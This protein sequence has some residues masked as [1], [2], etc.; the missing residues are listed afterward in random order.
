MIIFL[1]GFNLLIYGIDRER[2]HIFDES[3]YILAG[4][5]LAQHG[6][7]E[8]WTHPPL[9]KML[10]GAGV[11][12]FG[13]NPLGWRFMSVLFGTLSLNAMYALGLVLFESEGAALEVVIL[14]F[15]NQLLF[16]QSR[17]ALLEIFLFA[18]IAWAFVFFFRSRKS[19]S[20]GLSYSILAGVFL[21]LALATKWVAWIP[22][23]L[24]LWLEG[25]GPRTM[26][27]ALGLW[28]FV[29]L[30][31]YATVFLFCLGMVHPS[32][33]TPLAHSAASVS[34]GASRGA[35]SSSGPSRPSGSVATH[36]GA[37]DLVSLQ[38]DM[39]K[40]QLLFVQPTSSEQSHWYAWPFMITPNWYANHNVKINDLSLRSGVILLG[41]PLILWGG[42]EAV[43]FCLWAWFRNRQPTA[44]RISL[45]YFS[46]FLSWAVI[47]RKVMYFYY[48]FPAA[49]M[50]SLA[51]VF[52]FRYRRLPRW[53]H[54]V[55]VS[56]CGLVFAYFYPLLASVELPAH[57]FLSH[58]W[59]P[60]WRN[61]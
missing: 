23:L 59:L 2:T 41:N 31:T 43:F 27:R 3:R 25:L 29:P 15:F 21:G 44:K 19:P 11:W 16:V 35:S 45:L 18:W 26:L 42:L 58:L 24:C 22:M 61:S 60:S 8:N 1:V 36:Y 37:S 49:M 28:I 50:L 57:S 53:A 51:I 55:F 40:A 48:Y 14:C 17:I 33:A 52:S 12:L 10:I 4:I 5:Q 20:F 47:P 32:Y 54:W 7:N 13:D 46:L 39:L 56:A 38:Y 34:L 30:L 6:V 9:G